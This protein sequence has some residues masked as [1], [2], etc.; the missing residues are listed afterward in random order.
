MAY[1]RN[2]RILAVKINGKTFLIEKMIENYA[3]ITN[4]NVLGT[5]KLGTLILGG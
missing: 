3:P 5:G 2:K 4:P 1:I